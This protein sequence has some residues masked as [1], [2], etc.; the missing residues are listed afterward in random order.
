MDELLRLHQLDQNINTIA[1]G[2]CVNC[3]NSNNPHKTAQCGANT[4]SGDCHAKGPATDHSGKLQW[5][6]TSA[7]GFWPEQFSTV[8]RMPSIWGM[9]A[10]FQIT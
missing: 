10:L 3:I 8:S 1:T 6:T 5:R 2:C 4:M 7:H 9:P